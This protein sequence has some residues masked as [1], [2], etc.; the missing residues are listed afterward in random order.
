MNQIPEIILAMLMGFFL[1]ILILGVIR[2]GIIVVLCIIDMIEE[3]SKK[4]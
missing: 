2:L 3:I 1:F 4:Q